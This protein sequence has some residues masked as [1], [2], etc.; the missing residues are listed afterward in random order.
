[1]YGVGKKICP[2]LVNA[3]IKTIGDLANFSTDEVRTDNRIYRIGDLKKCAIGESSNLIISERNQPKSIGRQ[4]SL[5]QPNSSYLEL[6]NLL[7]R[8]LLNICE[9]SQKQMLLGKTIEIT[10]IDQQHHAKSKQKNLAK[11]TNN[12]YVLKSYVLKLFEEN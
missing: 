9:R 2:V 5:L 6:T 7:L 8:L 4:H 3:G 11:Y 10:M 12:Y 1:M